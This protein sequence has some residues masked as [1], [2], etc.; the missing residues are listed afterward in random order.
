MKPRLATG[1]AVAVQTGMFSD[2]L[3]SP[4]KLVEGNLLRVPV[5]KERI[6]GF[7]GS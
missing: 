7:P 3:E 5:Y 1:T 6:I 4:L 2:V